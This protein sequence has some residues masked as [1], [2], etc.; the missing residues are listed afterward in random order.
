MRDA[1]TSVL[2]IGIRKNEFFFSEANPEGVANG[3]HARL[4]K[5]F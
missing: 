1:E 2:V 3:H 4:G 5:A